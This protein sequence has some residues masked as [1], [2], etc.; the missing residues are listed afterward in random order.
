MNPSSLFVYT[1][2][3]LFASRVPYLLNRKLQPEIACQEVVLEKL[4]FE[5]LG[6]CADKLLQQG[7]RTTMHAPFLNFNCGSSKRRGRSTSMK[8]AANALQLAEKLRAKRI[9]F[10][11]GLAHGSDGKK[12]DIWLKNSVSFWSEFVAQAEAIDCTICIENIYEATPEIFVNLLK[13]INSPYVG[14]VFDIGHWNIFSS[15]K[16]SDWLDTTAPYLKHI[17]LHDN[18]GKQ[19]EHLAVGE[20]YIPF[21]NLFAWLKTIDSP[22]TLT[23]ENHTLP[24][25]ELSLQKINKYF[26]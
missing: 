15:R 14:H 25:T 12:L 17:H 23:L 1:P 22:P 10:H 8:L 3:H 16:L 19:D 9:V 24:A 20:G 2:A 26:Y 4:D 6:D 11:P 5:L 18:H 21:A 7:L 13:E